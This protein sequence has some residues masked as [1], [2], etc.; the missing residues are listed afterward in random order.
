VST[1]HGAFQ[2]SNV[3]NLSKRVGRRIRALR[4]SRNMSQEQLAERAGVSYKFV[5]DVERGQGNPT[6]SWLEAVARGL[7]VA[8]KDLL[9]DEEPPAVVYPTFSGRDY[10]VMREAKETLETLLVRHAPK[11]KSRARSS[12]K[13]KKPR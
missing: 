3:N 13:T 4:A 6:L 7:G 12:R 10:V 1:G 5:G 9:A 8:V 11:S 2:Y